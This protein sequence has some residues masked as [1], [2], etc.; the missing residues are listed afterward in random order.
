LWAQ[1]AARGLVCEE[2]RVGGAQVEAIVVENFDV[3][4]LV[5]ERAGDLRREGLTARII[6]PVEASADSTDP[7]LVSAEIVKVLARVARVGDLTMVPVRQTEPISLNT[8]Y[9]V[10]DFLRQQGIQ[11]VLVVAPALRSQRS[12][13][14][15]GTVLGPFGIAMRCVPV[16]GQQTPETW[17]DTW[18][19]VEQVLE[20]YIKLEYYRLFILPR[21]RDTSG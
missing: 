10:R 16:F 14:I 20:Q 11:S 5:F 13:L 1:A 8:A 19:G 18:H 21:A 17:L 9:G 6:V 12:S 7:N 3:D 2:Q 4:Y 15:Y